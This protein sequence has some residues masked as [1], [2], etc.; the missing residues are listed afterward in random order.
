MGG[1]ASLRKSM[2]DSVAQDS[3]GHVLNPSSAPPVWPWPSQLRQQTSW[4]KGAST[5]TPA[6][7]CHLASVSASSRQTAWCSAP[8]SA[9]AQ[10]SAV[11]GRIAVRVKTSSA[12]RLTEGGGG[13]CAAGSNQC[14]TVAPGGGGGAAAAATVSSPLASCEHEQRV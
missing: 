3:V 13:G 5:P 11:R 9:P 10:M 1:H 2:H 7:G 8:S 14:R 6:I 12:A 4:Q